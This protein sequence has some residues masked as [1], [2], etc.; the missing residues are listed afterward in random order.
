MALINA[1]DGGSVL[2]ELFFFAVDPL[3]S[4]IL[5]KGQTSSTFHGQSFD[6]TGETLQFVITSDGQIQ[7]NLTAGTLTNGYE[8]DAT[9]QYAISGNAQVKSISLP[10]LLTGPQA[11]TNGAQV[12]LT[13][14][15][16]LGAVTPDPAVFADAS[17]FVG[18]YIGANS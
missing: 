5:V 15:G 3:F 7:L 8:I 2:V 13:Y 17:E 6:G 4:Q 18:L 14:S 12:D 16:G 1:F 11:I 9:P 10:N